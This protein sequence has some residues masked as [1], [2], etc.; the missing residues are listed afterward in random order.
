M[1]LFFRGQSSSGRCPRIKTALSSSAPQ[2]PALERGAAPAPLGLG[3]HR[4]RELAEATG[5]SHTCF[6]DEGRGHHFDGQVTE[7]R[8]GLDSLTPSF[9]FTSEQVSS[10][11]RGHAGH[12]SARR[13]LSCFLRSRTCKARHS[14]QLGCCKGDV[15]ATE[16]ESQD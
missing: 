7:V 1:S 5:Q 15:A 9:P 12:T 10:L 3:A 6:L 8:S 4:R 11:Q 13:A 16:A 2:A 14:C